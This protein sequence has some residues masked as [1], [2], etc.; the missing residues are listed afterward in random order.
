MTAFRSDKQD[1]VA[2]P[3]ET[4][5]VGPHRKG[6]LTMKVPVLTAME[7]LPVV[8]TQDDGQVVKPAVRRRTVSVGQ[9]VPR[10]PRTAI[11]NGDCR[12]LDASLLDDRWIAVCFPRTVNEI[13][14]DRLNQYATRLSET[15]ALVLGVM[16]DEVLLEP[17]ASG[18]WRQLQMPLVTD[19]LGRLHRLY[20]MAPDGRAPKTST[21]L[22]APDRVLKHH[23]LHGLS[24]WDLEAV[25]RLVLLELEHHRRSQAALLE[26]SQTCHR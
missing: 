5:P 21:F 10:F 16:S 1:S 6:R 15:G 24:T 22:I 20:G 9:V 26:R 4:V 13:Q 14:M 3:A 25:H 7:R 12:P 8:V 18:S 2:V 11:V 23:L 19:S 17:R